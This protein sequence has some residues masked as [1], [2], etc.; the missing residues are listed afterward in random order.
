[1]SESDQPVQAKMDLVKALISSLLLAMGIFVTIVLPAEFGI[2]PVGIGAMLG[3]SALNDEDNN[4]EIISRRGEGDLLFRQDEVEILLPANEGLE[5]KFF[6]DMHANITYEWESSASL[7]FDMH[8]EPDGDTSGY[9]ES[10]G[11]ASADKMSG[12]ITVPFA[13]SHGWYWRNDTNKEVII[14]LKTLGNYDVI[15]LK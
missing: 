12:S 6:L 14:D 3:L 8:G 7:Y 10:Y 2:D 9:F 11:E 15:G 4:R 13:G 5:Y 1:M